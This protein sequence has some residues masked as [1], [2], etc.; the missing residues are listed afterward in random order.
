LGPGC[1]GNSPGAAAL[2]EELAQA[3]ISVDAKT[4]ADSSATIEIHM[5]IIRATPAIELWSRV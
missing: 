3:C 2:G 1:T 4:I 5:T